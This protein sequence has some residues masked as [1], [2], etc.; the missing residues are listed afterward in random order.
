[1]R[2]VVPAFI[3]ALV[4]SIALS[5]TPARAQVV[6]TGQVTSYTAPTGTTAAPTGSSYVAAEPTPTRYVH[7]SSNIPALWVPGLILLVGGY[8][9]NVLGLSYAIA[10]QLN[11]YPNTDWYLYGLVPLAG[12]F[13][14]FLSDGPQAEG[15]SIITGVAQIAGLVMLILGF[16]IQDEW[17]EPVYVFDEENPYS[18]RLSFNLEGAPGGGAVGTA[19]LTHF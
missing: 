4:V 19:T 2:Y 1:M 6:I 16:A 5:A 12:P 14:Q 9:V 3:A 10:S 17:D 18:P 11:I 15:L 13:L 8:A 7:H